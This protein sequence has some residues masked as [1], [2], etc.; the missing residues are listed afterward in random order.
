LHIKAI[1]ANTVDGLGVHFW[2]SHKKFFV[3]FFT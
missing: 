3:A 1:T 2:C